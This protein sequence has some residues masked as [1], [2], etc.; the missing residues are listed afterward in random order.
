MSVEEMVLDIPQETR[1]FAE[2]AFQKIDKKALEHKIIQRI[3]GKKYGLFQ[4]GSGIYSVIP[5]A[6][7]YSQFAALIAA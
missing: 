7:D 2:L 4:F 5:L 1:D 6:P 3:E